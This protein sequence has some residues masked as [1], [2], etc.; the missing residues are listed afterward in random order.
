MIDDIPPVLSCLETL[1]VAANSGCSFIGTIPSP[2][3]SDNCT[4]AQ[5]ITLSSNAPGIFPAGETTVT[6]SAMDT[7]GNSSECSVVVTVADETPPQIVCPGALTVE[8]NTECGFVGSIGNATATDGCTLS[9]AL[10]LSNDAPET[11]PVG[12]T[13]VTWS[14]TDSAGNSTSCAST[15]T[16]IDR[17]PPQITCSTS[18]I[19]VVADDAC[20]YS[21]PFEE[22]TVTDT[23]S[24]PQ[25]IELTNDV[26]D[27]LPLGDNVVTWTATDA[28]GNT[29]T[30]TVRV[31][32]EDQT[33]P[34]ITCPAPITTACLGNDG[35]PVG[36]TLGAVDNCDGSPTVTSSHESGSVFPLGTT[37]VTCT[38]TDSG[39]NTSTCTFEV[40]VRCG[41]Q[42]PGDCNSDGDVNIS[43]AICLL[44][45]LFLGA[46]DPLL[47]CGDTSAGHP[48]NIELLSWDGAGGLDLSDAIGVLNWRFLGG[49]A[50]ILG[51]SC[52]SVASCPEVCPLD[53]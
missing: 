36:F 18:L 22:P 6:W 39:A 51:T 21:G 20:G 24:T 19:L 16:V 50:H 32:V 12:D 26:S 48:G 44:G 41:G 17:T 27:A 25:A 29:S 13:I 30:C 2:T 14:A 33:P 43:D 47:P 10:V 8:A 34:T 45:V 28:A 3:A 38:A 4:A 11:L 23:C 31:L 9:S 5:S 15:V 37:L 52:T 7:S 40:T 53:G 35:A 46:T 49:P 1:T 42:L